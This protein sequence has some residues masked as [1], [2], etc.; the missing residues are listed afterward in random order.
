MGSKCLNSCRLEGSQNIKMSEI[1]IREYTQ[2]F[3][4]KREMLTKDVIFWGE[5]KNY[6]NLKDEM[7]K[8][9]IPS[10]KEYGRGF[11]LDRQGNEVEK[12]YSYHAKVLVPNWWGWLY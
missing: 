11:T 10:L 2:G 7:F 5:P 8:R 6:S 3:R 12:R 1:N 9:D 4:T